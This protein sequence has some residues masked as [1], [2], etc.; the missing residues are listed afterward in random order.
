MSD[1]NDSKPD[2]ESDVEHASSSPD[3]VKKWT[4]IVLLLAVVFLVLYLLADRHTPFSSQARVHALVVPVAAEVSGRVVDVVAT[5]NQVV[6]K[7]DE[8]FRIDTSNYELAV[9]N[10][11]ASLESARQATGASSATVDAALAGL[12]SAQAN[13]TRARQDVTRLRRIKAEDP[14]AISDRRLDSAE[15]SLQVAEQQVAAAEA[16][17]AGARSSLGSD[18]DRNSR[19]QQALAGLETA[20]L[21]LRRTT[22]VAPD[23]G[24]VT[25]IR[26]DRGN[27]AG[28]GVPQM[29]FISA[30]DVWVRAD[31]TENNLGHVDRDDT[32]EVVFD[33][34]PGRVFKG[35][36]RN[37]GYGVAV[38]TAPLG[39]L[40]TI[41][42]DR[43]WLRDAQRFPVVIDFEMKPEEMRR[44]RVGAQASVIVYASDSFILNTLGKLYVRVTSLL[45]YAY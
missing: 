14:G 35:S 30:S 44:L 22:V 27:F 41:N 28:A 39:A 25:D 9:A 42:N 34:Y 40:P 43:Q 11:E 37:V 18:G 29:T 45:S 3:P 23:G 10:A 2:N 21:N 33:I 12:R 15:A 17:V 5:N 1:N 20:Q 36:V 13:L 16:N 38:D 6:N 26:V 32:V 24:V 7:G 4:R 31:F 8:L 19:V